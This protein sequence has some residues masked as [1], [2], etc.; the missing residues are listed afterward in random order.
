[1]WRA[2]QSDRRFV[3]EVQS[4]FSEGMEMTETTIRF[5]SPPL[6][7][8][9]PHFVP[10]VVQVFRDHESGIATLKREQHLK[11]DE[12]LAVL[13]ADLEAIGFSVERLRRCTGT[14]V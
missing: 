12:V 6:T 4:G 7:E 2:E 8:P 10:Q 3:D 9:P 1:V 11:S 14:V 13:R 5:I